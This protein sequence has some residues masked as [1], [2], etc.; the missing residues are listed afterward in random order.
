MKVTVSFRLSADLVYAADTLAPRYGSRSKVLE[1]A[2]RSFLMGL[3]SQH[4]DARDAEILVTCADRINEEAL[5]VLGYQ[6]AR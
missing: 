1:V 6:A 3:E 4:L 2:L 5:D